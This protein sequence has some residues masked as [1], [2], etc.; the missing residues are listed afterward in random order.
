MIF[1]WP[2]SLIPQRIAILPPRKTVGLGESLN[3]FTQ[4]A[5]AIRPPFG[6]R[7]QFGNLF[8]AEVRAWRAMMGLFEGRT[9]TVR[10]PL[11]DL[12]QRSDDAAIGA[13]RATH[14]DGSYFADGARYLTDDVAG[15]AVSAQQGERTIAVDFG[16]YG[17]VLDAGL[18]FGLGD[19]PYLVRR[20]WWAGNVAR[21]ETTPSFRTAYVA[22]PLK[23]RP[24]MIAGLVDDDQG[25]LMLERARYGAPT[26]D[27][28]ERFA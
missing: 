24:T 19:H 11:F 10:I 12:W 5:P 8:G 2:A 28:V 21:I 13:G 4:A 9:N 7:L 1:D 3:G 22:Q 25:E 6:L 18:Y 17:Q 16:A 14:S 20:I 26:L 27:L 23:L 15:I